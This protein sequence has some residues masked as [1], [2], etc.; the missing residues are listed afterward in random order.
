MDYKNLS[1]AELGFFLLTYSQSMEEFIIDSLS[2]QVDEP[3][4]LYKP[5]MKSFLLYCLSI[6]LNDY[7]PNVDSMIV[8]ILDE[9]GSEI[10]MYASSVFPQSRSAK[11]EMLSA[12]KEYKR[13]E[14][15]YGLN[16]VN[17]IEEAFA[18]NVYRH[19]NINADGILEAILNPLRKEF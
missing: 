3:G 4:S 15:S 7:Y 8:K 19:G 14:N 10:D 18:K 5:A 13:L 6:V 11:T 9:I 17:K 16:S 2:D 12:F 1:D